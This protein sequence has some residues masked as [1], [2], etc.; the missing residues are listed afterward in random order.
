MVSIFTCLIGA[1]VIIPALVLI[2]RPRFLESNEKR[3]IRINWKV[4]TA[5][6]RG[7][8]AIPTNQYR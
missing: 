1:L 2:F 7:R 4:Q 5:W 3:K 6:L 8:K